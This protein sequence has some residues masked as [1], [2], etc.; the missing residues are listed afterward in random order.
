MNQSLRSTFPHPNLSY[1]AASIKASDYVR[2]GV[3]VKSRPTG[4][5]SP[6]FRTFPGR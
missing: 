6:A 1:G 5:T 4:N 2:L 3:H